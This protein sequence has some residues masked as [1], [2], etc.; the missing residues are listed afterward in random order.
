MAAPQVAWGRPLKLQWAQHR[1]SANPSAPGE[2]QS[3]DVFVG[4]LARDIDE[5]VCQANWLLL[6]PPL[7]A[8]AAAGP[9]LCCGAP[10][11]SGDTGA[12]T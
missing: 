7:R 6:P 9:C 10:P 5:Q 2:G 12:P 8:A 3:F 1:G 4:D 11:G